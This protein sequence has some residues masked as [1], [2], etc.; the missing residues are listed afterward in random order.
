MIG[1]TVYYDEFLRYSSMAQIQQEESN[2]GD[3]AHESG[4]V[5][6]DLM[7]HVKLYDVVE[8]RY[9][10]FTQLILDIWYGK[11]RSHPY[12][13]QLHSVRK[14]ICQ[15]FSG[16]RR[17]RTL[18]EM[19]YV[20]LVHRLAGSGINYAKL[21]GGYHNT[22]LPEFYQASSISEMV[23]I[24]RRYEKPK[25]TSVG[26]QYPAF[27]K[28]PK[29]YS[30]GGDYFLCEILP[31][32]V[33]DLAEFL[34]RRTHELREVGE[35]MFDW[36]ANRGYRRYKFQYA[37]AISDIADFYPK[38]VDGQSHF[39]YGSNAIECMRYMIDPKDRK[40]RNA[41]DL[42]MEKAAA[43]TGHVPYNLEDQMCDCIRW[44]ENY[45]QPG[46][47]YDHL[48]LNE[49]WSSHRITDHPFG[50]QKPMLEL[51]LVSDFNELNRHPADDL[52][53]KSAG[54]TAADYQQLVRSSI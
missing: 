33:E 1:T 26:Y 44:V 32:L 31:E 16:W 49:I 15:N 40:K 46:A 38:L 23:E 54:I 51:G 22:V 2:L 41:L 25:Y 29:G 3:I 37:A 53:I 24:I 52:I 8:R 30:R 5:D 28:P 34:Q 21:P 4:S 42:L 48:D 35:F 45:I 27:P 36:N 47:D 14:P 43:D 20:F 18:P 17:K 6:D 7:R 13:G 11:S 39:Y 50:R 12:Y 10:G 19:L 9:A